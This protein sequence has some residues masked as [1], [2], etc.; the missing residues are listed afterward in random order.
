[1]LYII[2]L[3]LSIQITDMPIFVARYLANVSPHYACNNDAISLHAQ[4]WT[5]AR[6]KLIAESCKDFQ[7]ISHIVKT[8]VDMSQLT[9]Q[10]SSV[11]VNERELGDDLV[12][13][14]SIDD[15]GDASY[16]VID[17]LSLC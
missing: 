4:K 9:A 5:K 16:R 14:D 8:L 2:T 1:M 12:R 7:T 3:L 15:I 10:A 6:I 17:E 13:A 11:V